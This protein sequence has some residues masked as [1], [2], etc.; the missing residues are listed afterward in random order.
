MRVRSCA[1]RGAHK[2]HV[3]LLHTRLAIHT[4]GVDFA[5]NAAALMA[6]NDLPRRIHGSI[7]VRLKSFSSKNSVPGPQ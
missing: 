6:S 1:H 5:P 2:Y 4:C 7:D 3:M